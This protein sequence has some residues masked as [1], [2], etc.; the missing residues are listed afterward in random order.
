MTKTE[1]T[2]YS[3]VLLKEQGKVF[4]G[5]SCHKMRMS[6]GGSKAPRVTFDE[7]SISLLSN[8]NWVHC[9]V[10]EG[11]SVISLYSR[12]ALL[13]DAHRMFEE[14]PVSSWALIIAG[15][16]K[17]WHADMCLELPSNEGFR[18]QTKLFYIH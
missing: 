11:T 13:G 2:I 4:M 7:E 3:S 17:D 15:F 16:V 12:R 1:I 9:Y 8:N 5:A 10:Y 18:F 6:S 14:I